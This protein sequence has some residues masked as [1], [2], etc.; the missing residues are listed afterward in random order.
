MCKLL[1][2]VQCE[3]VA[4]KQLLVACLSGCSKGV[5]FSKKVAW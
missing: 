2:V 1:P 4:G 3:A 5:P